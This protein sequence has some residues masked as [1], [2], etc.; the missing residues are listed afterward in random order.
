M[1]AGGSGVLEIFW[2]FLEFSAECTDF[3]LLLGSLVINEAKW[4]GTAL[5]TSTGYERDTVL[6]GSFKLASPLVDVFLYEGMIF[7]T[8][9]KKCDQKQPSL[10]RN[11]LALL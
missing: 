8:I 3:Y 5:E 4:E 11:L 6:R 2:N 10:G 7:R 9:W 1:G